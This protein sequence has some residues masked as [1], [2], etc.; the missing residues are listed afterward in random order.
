MFYQSRI[1]KAIQRT[2]LVLLVLCLFGTNGL[3][4]TKNPSAAEGI[5]ATSTGLKRP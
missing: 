4:E 2:A 5:S 1:I 3:A